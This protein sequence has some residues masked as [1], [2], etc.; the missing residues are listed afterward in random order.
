MPNKHFN[1]RFLPEKQSGESVQ[2]IKLKMLGPDPDKDKP[3]FRRK[4]I[5]GPNPLSCKKKQK[6]KSQQ[7]VHKSSADSVSDGKV[8]KRKNRKRVKVPQHVKEHLKS[9]A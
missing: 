9:Q 3:I 1:F 6:K 7:L 4:K 8:A 5:K 2:E